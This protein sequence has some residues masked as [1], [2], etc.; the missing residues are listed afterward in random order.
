MNDS[1]SNKIVSPTSSSGSILLRGCV[2][3]R[4]GSISFRATTP[5]FTLDRGLYT[6]GL[7][8][9]IHYIYNVTRGNNRGV[10]IYRNAS[11]LRFSTTTLS[12]TLT[13][14]GTY[15]I[16]ID[17]GCPLSSS[18]SG[19]FTGFRTTISFLGGGGSHNIHISCGGVN[20]RYTKVL[21]T[22]RLLACPRKDTFLTRGNCFT[23]S[24]GRGFI[25]GGTSRGDGGSTFT[26]GRYDT[27]TT[28]LT[29]FKVSKIR[30]PRQSRILTLRYIPK[31]SCGFGMDRGGTI[32]LHPCRDKAL[33]AT[34][35]SFRGFYTTY[36]RGGVPIFTISIPTNSVCRDSYTFS[37]L[38]VVPLSLAFS[39]TCVET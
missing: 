2:T 18:Q 11:A 33:G 15:T 34:D 32:V 20:S 12:C 29:S 35:L 38:K 6:R 8:S 10:V 17:T 21:S 28:S 16:L 31:Y 22:T 36:G 24:G 19:N 14:A 23:L 25:G 5:C 26:Y 13:N 30:F 7:G 27:G 4:N 1:I 39:G 9:L 3:L 37:F